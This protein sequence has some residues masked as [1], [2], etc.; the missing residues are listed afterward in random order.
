MEENEVE[1]QCEEL[2][3]RVV[4]T[5]DPVLYD[6]KEM[7]DICEMFGSCVEAWHRRRSMVLANPKSYGFSIH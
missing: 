5:F 6:R 2:G 3:I 7:E 1:L 4:T